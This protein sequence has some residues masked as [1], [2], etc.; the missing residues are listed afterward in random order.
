MNSIQ[1]WRDALSICCDEPSP[2]FCLHTSRQTKPTASSVHYT[3]IVVI[4]A[5]S[6]LTGWLCD[7]T[8]MFLGKSNGVWS[9]SF[10]AMM[11]SPFFLTFLIKNLAVDLCSERFLHVSL[12]FSLSVSVVRFSFLSSISPLSS[13]SASPLFSRNTLPRKQ[14]R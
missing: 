6:I 10:R 13:P 4:E 2:P 7:V 14:D 1:N 8:G 12:K 5:D 3:V 11:T 9:Q